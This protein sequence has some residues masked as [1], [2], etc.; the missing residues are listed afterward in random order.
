MKRMENLRSTQWILRF[1]IVMAALILLTMIMSVET[2][3]QVDPAKRYAKEHSDKNFWTVMGRN[4][5]FTLSSLKDDLKTAKATKKANKKK[6]KAQD[7]KNAI[8]ARIEK[9]KDK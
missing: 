4:E 1:I 8:L 7:K 2:K 3:A 5:S 9:I 6:A